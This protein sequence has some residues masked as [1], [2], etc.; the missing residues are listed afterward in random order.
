VFDSSL[1][2]RE[3]W[4]HDE[5]DNVADFFV[6]RLFSATLNFR[7]MALAKAF[8]ILSIED[9]CRFNRKN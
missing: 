6:L 1:G 8:R 4:F 2:E 9:R 3:E 7:S 5:I